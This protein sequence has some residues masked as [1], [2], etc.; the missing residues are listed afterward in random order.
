MQERA[1]CIIALIL[2]LDC[3]ATQ[4]MPHGPI[5]PGWIDEPESTLIK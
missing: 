4:S 3:Q 1:L 2:T 5:Q